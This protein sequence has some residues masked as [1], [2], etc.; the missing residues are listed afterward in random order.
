MADADAW[1]ATL[2]DLGFQVSSLKNG[3]AT[4]NSILTELR[5]II[6]TSKAGDIVVFQ[7]AGHGTEVDDLDGDELDGTNGPK[8]EALCPHD[9]AEGAYLLD[10]DIADIFATIPQGVNVTCF[11]DCCHSGSITRAFVGGEPLTGERD[12]KA[13]FL[14]ATPEMQAQHRAYRARIGITRSEPGRRQENLKN[15]LFS[16]CRDFEG[17]YESAGYG[18]FTVRATKILQQGIAGM[19]NEDFQKQLIKEFG[20]GP[21]QNPEL[22]CAPHMNKLPLLNPLMI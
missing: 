18:E 15:I 17:A 13:R 8:D 4:R 5:T 9:I 6:E 21:R 19:T 16:A 22:D 1:G 3:A 11:I 10:D 20:P 7:F 2:S 12:L 14:P